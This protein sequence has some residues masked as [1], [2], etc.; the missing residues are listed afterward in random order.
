MPELEHALVELGRSIDYPPTPE[1]AGAVRDR[2]PER[3]RAR[4]GRRYAVAAFAILAVAA[5]AVMAVPQTRGAV[6]G[7]FHL[8]GTTIERVETL[9]TVETQAPLDLGRRVTLDEAERF[10]RWDLVRPAALGDPDVVYVRSDLPGG[11]VTFVY[12]PPSSPRALVSQFEG[13]LEYV[14]KTVGPGTRVD[15]GRVGRE[16]GFWIFGRP[17]IVRFADRNGG[18]RE[19]RVRLAG[20]VL[21]WQRGPVTV[22]LEADVSRRRALAVARSLEPVG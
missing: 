7:F 21:L 15:A 6:L 13:G 8:G 16:R 12:G 11:V 14:E 22:R 17:H 2:L 3:Q 19:D 20:D 18:F 9:P 5:G 4:F 10:M 1:L